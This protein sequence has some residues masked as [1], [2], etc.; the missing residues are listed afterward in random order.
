MAK[1]KKLGP[2]SEPAK[3]VR[4]GGAIGDTA[5]DELESWTRNGAGVDESEENVGSMPNER[6][7][8]KVNR[9]RVV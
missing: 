2:K 9:K 7:M 3:W 4:S 6:V 8:R 1:Q 5:M